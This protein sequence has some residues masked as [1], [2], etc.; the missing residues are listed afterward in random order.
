MA[1]EPKYRPYLTLAQ[2]QALLECAEDME[3]CS[4]YYNENLRPAI[5]NL[6]MLLLKIDM[7]ATSSAYVPTG[8]KPGPASQK[9]ILMQGEDKYTESAS[10]VKLSETPE[11]W[12][13]HYT[14]WKLYSSL[15]Q[16]PAPETLAGAQKWAEYCENNGLNADTEESI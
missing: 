15:G 4:G 2:I 14:E 11:S 7:G 12:R 16:N 1:T 6:K 5:N 9:D 3:N 8:N 13:V 10:Q